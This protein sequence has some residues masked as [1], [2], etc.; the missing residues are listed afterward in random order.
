M[1]YER[2]KVEFVGRWGVSAVAGILIL[3]AVAVRIFLGHRYEQDHSRASP[4]HHGTVTEF[5]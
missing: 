2:G 4:G 1:V 3:E 5:G